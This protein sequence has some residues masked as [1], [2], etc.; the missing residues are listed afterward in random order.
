ME[1]SNN[2]ALRINAFIESLENDRDFYDGDRFGINPPIAAPSTI[3]PLWICQLKLMDHERFI[4]RGIPTGANGAPVDGLRDI[5]FG[6]PTD[7]ITT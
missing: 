4:D 3:K 5:V 1:T 6:S 2:S 7:N